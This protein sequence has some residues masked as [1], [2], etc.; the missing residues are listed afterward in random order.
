VLW[1]E[2]IK[3]PQNKQLQYENKKTKFESE[4]KEKS[5]PLSLL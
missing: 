3:A 5:L 2:L 4:G 1:L